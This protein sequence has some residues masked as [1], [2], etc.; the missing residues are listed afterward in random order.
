MFSSQCRHRFRQPIDRLQDPRLG[1]QQNAGQL[2]GVGFYQPGDCIDI[3]VG[4]NQHLAG[5]SRSDAPNPGHRSRSR[6]IP[7]VFQRGR[8]ADLNRVVAAVIS[9]LELGDP[10]PPGDPAGQPD[11]VQGGFGPR[12]AEPHPLQARHP[13]TQLLS[14][15]GLHPRRPSQHDSPGDLRIDRLDHGRMIVAQHLRGVM[16]GAV[17]K[18]AA[19]D[20]GQPTAGT[21]LEE[22]GVGRIEVRPLGTAGH[23]RRRTVKSGPRR[24]RHRLVGTID[25]LTGFTNRHQ[26]VLHNRGYS[27]K[28]IA[29]PRRAA[30][31]GTGPG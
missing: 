24:R 3:V 15:L 14:Q 30:R 29:R 13:V 18:R 2:V 8:H 10:R 27:T 11:R 12:I 31:P 25:T 21:T 28:P 7:R 16:V 23:H 22:Q 9:P 6:R 1:I 4:Q 5:R 26:Q 20:I 19:V 17:E